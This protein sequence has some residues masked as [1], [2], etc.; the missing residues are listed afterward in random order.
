MI[1]PRVRTTNQNRWT[2]ILKLRKS[3]KVSDQYTVLQRSNNGWYWNDGFHKL[4]IV[5]RIQIEVFLIKYQCLLSSNYC[6]FYL[7]DKRSISSMLERVTM[8]YQRLSKCYC[9]RLILDI[10]RRIT[11]KRRCAKTRI[12]LYLLPIP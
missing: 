7:G 11:D 2:T 1:I 12:Q 3:K 9:V 10:E 5:V 6:I 8:G 4:C